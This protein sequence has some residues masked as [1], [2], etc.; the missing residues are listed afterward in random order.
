MWLCPS[1]DLELLSYGGY[2]HGRYDM[3]SYGGLGY[4]YYWGYSYNITPSIWAEPF[5]YKARFFHNPVQ[6]PFQYC[7]DQHAGGDIY[8]DNSHHR[9]SRPT[10]FMDGHVALLN[11]NVEYLLPTSQGP[12]PQL[13]LATYNG[14]NQIAWGNW[15]LELD[16]Y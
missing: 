9:K 14:I 4:H 7:S 11:G 16:E 6:T 2:G 10:A 1:D 3:N 8:G 15:Q 12:N 13:G 5:T